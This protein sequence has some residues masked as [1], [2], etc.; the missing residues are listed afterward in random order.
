MKSIIIFLLFFVTFSILAQNTTKPGM[1]LI[2]EQ[3]PAF[4]ASTTMGKIKFPYDYFGKW[5]ILFSHPADFT[6]V[7]TSELLVL[8]SMQ[9]EFKKL[10]AALVVVSTDGINSH[11]EWIRSME[12]I[13]YKNAETEKFNFPLVSDQSMEVAKLYGMIHPNYNSTKNIRAVFIIDTENVIRAIFYYPNNIGRNM[14]ELKRSLIAL[15]TADSKS[16]LTPANWQPGDD[17]LVPAPSTSI[18]AEKM[19]NR[20][21]PNLYSL[22]WYMWFMKNQK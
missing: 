21:D 19:E 1:P 13:K 14:D 10:N 18:E 8:A 3:A 7:C 5:K 20:K 9:S 22:S 2:G 16:L 15:Q 12:S 4:E 17:Y 11:M 6:P